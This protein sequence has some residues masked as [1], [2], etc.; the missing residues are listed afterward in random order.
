MNKKIVFYNI[1]KAMILEGILLMLSLIV[2][3]M[4]NEPARPFVI[5]IIIA[6]ALGG[7][8]SVICKTDGKGLYIRDGFAI[9]TLSWIS[10]SLIGSLPFFISGEIPS[11]VDSFFETMSGFTT[12]GASILTDVESMSKGMLFWR[13]STHWIGGMGVL[14]FILAIAEKNPNRSI[15]ILRAEM[16]G[17]KVDKFTPKAKNT[18]MVLYYIYM[19]LTAVLVLFL[20]AGGMSPYDSVVHAMATAG[21]GGFAIHSDSIGSYSPYIQYVLSVAMIIFGINFSLYYLILLGKWKK[22]LQSSELHWFA[23][24]VAISTLAIT[25]N[26]LPRFNNVEE[27]FRAAIFQVA[28]I[29]STTGFSSVDYNLWPQFSKSI[30]FIL[31]I[32]G[33]C[34]GST[35]GG[36]KIS[37]VMLLFHSVKNEARRVIHPN[38]IN[39]TIINGKPISKEGILGVNAYLALYIGVWLISF[40]LISTDNASFETNLSAVTACISNVGPGFAGAGPF[41]SY[42]NYSNFSKIV[43]S[44]T[45]L[46]GRLEIYPVLLGLVYRK[47]R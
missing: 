39:S 45:M 10:L 3:L 33:A 31:T 15:N 19:A 43:L 6:I 16:P 8:L 9:A 1:G 23:V 36:L 18:A 4:Y 12:T 27:S 47:S 38:I 32:F 30:L 34:E 14:V 28:S 24:I 26:I 25:I 7:F 5:A 37:R 21:T 40:I 13:S 29:I 41:S 42:A 20:L 2:A 44:L 35:S 46:L 17:T 11:Y 22:S